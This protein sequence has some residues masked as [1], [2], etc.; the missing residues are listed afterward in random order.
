MGLLRPRPAS[1]KTFVLEDLPLTREA[2]WQSEDVTTRKINESSRVPV[3]PTEYVE[4]AFFMPHKGE[5]KNFSFAGR[6]YLKTIYN[7]DA[8]RVLLI[9]GRQV[10]K[11]CRVTS[12]VT[13]STGQQVEAGDVKVGDDL[14]TM[15][16]DGITMTTGKVVWVSRRYT[17]PC[18]RVRTRQGHVFEIAL[19][20]PLRLW[21]RWVEGA[22]LQVGDR[23]ASIRK[24]GVFTGTASMSDERVRLTAYLIG[25]GCLG[26]GYV[27]FTQSPGKVLKEFLADLSAVKGT[28]VLYGKK[29]TAAK[30][31][32]LRQGVVHRWL[33]EDGLLGHKSGTK[34]IPEWVFRLDRRQTA[35]FV[36]RLWATDGHVKRV[37]SSQ[38]SIEYCSISQRLVKQVQS[39]LWKFG[40]PSKIRENWPS[41][42][43]KRGE[44]KVA[45]ILR[46]ETQEGVRTFLK[47]I[48]A[49]AKSEKVKSPAC[50]SSNNR[51][52]LPKGVNLLVK[53]ILASRGSDDWHEN[54]KNRSLYASGLRRT[55]KYAPTREKILEYVKFFRSDD[56]FDQHLVDTLEGH[57][58]S[59]LYWDEIV[60]IT[61]VGPQECID[62]EIEGTHNF[63]A[64]GLV[65]HNSTSLGNKILTLSAMNPYFRT[66]Y[67]SPSFP[68]TKTFSNDRIKDPITNSSRLR[69]LT[70]K[71]L[72]TNVLEKAFINGSKITMRFAF[73]NADRVRGIP[74][75]Q[76]CIDEFQ[77]ILMDNVPVIEECASHSPYK[78]FLYSGTPKSLDNAIEHYW[79]R[80]STQNEWVIPCKHH[81]V[82]GDPSTWHWNIL[83]EDNI[84]TD[85]LICNK[86]GKPINAA[87]PDAQWASMNP[88]PKVEKPYEGYR[89]PQI[90]APWIEMADIRDKQK[91]YSRAKFY[92]EVLGR[93]YDSGT[94]PLTRV[95]V[96]KNSWDELSMD[97]YRQVIQWSTQYPI[98]MGVDW[99]CHDDQTRIL[100]LEGFKHF[101]DVQPSDKVAQFDQ[102]SRR[103]SF[104]TPKVL[105][106]RDWNGDLLHFK[107]K[108]LDMML[109]GTHRTLVKGKGGSWHVEPA[110]RLV[111][112]VGSAH[113]VGSVFWEG[114]ERKTFTLPGVPGSVG[115]SGCAERSF[116]MDDWLEF[117]GYYLSEG[118]RCGVGFKNPCLKMSQRET[119]NPEST[120]S[121][122]K[123]MV[124]LGLPFKEYPN[125]NTGDVNWTICGKQY[126]SWVDLN[127]GRKCDEKRIPREFLGLS[128]RQLRILFDAM[129][130]GDGSTDRR[131]GNHNGCY[132]STSKG[133]CEDFQELCIRLSLRS[134]LS[135]RRKAAGNRKNLWCVS[136]SGSRDYCYNFPN[137][138]E[139]VPYKGKVYCCSV[140]SGFIVTE[141]NG[142]IGYQGNTGENS[143]TVISL[144]GYLP[145]APDHYTCFYWKR[146]EGVESEPKVQLR[147]IKKLIED[148]NVRYVGV[149]YGG[150]F[151]PNDELTREYGADKIRKY[152]WVGQVKQKIKYEP[153]LGVPRFLCH[154]TEIMSDMFN[155]IKR[156]NVF[157]FPRW[158]EFDTFGQDFL[159]IF[160]EYNDRLKQNVYKHAPGQPDDA[161]HSLV[162][163]FLSSFYFRP[164]PDILLPSQSAS[165]L[166]AVGRLDDE[167]LE[168]LDI[169]LT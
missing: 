161:F 118:G 157:R 145:F 72:T 70:N 28:A 111:Q 131:K 132:L 13:T 34:F 30:S 169:K 94:R 3:L 120:A 43:K 115:Y 68:Q 52:T 39:L 61:H 73:L 26:S 130:L 167:S 162:F 165:P 117:L 20:H 57:A 96:Q 59:D 113:F 25:D 80:F 144:G 81:G 62:F 32:K 55:L 37:S 116:D 166:D 41:I 40:V 109:T 22:H 95:D 133:L 36:N 90:M 146:F 138:T 112:R 100:T 119:V 46:V 14:V 31:V 45:Y 107:R 56:G 5:L 108:G 150:G 60:E 2:L 128:V 53:E 12:S 11:T 143:N 64:E 29:S 1:Q 24:C 127:I 48:G 7:T 103:M 83:E 134:T 82:P 76:I 114:V 89:L 38:Y 87:D 142:R 51:D 122:R 151:W 86:C 6:P 9:A 126:W 33:A 50:S 67:V 19:T 99:G 152:Q 163:G 92:N 137:T 71:A 16:N 18:I 4:F 98:A 74:S 21:E 125:H 69:A 106:V 97:H 54:R 156:G 158:E 160:S 101:K 85:S 136:W 140:P 84:G 135:L 123:C 15:A 78:Y 139:R 93:S 129:M 124:R 164:R 65:T 141:R 47:D 35:L 110:E 159:N 88:N 66:L 104:V 155:A 168:E 10:E 8:H 79:T 23:L 17:K 102:H 121:M 148:F 77:D 91:K 63:V 49:L 147:V 75:D 42:Y 58:N 153:R 105:T 44:H 154:R 27:S 149:D